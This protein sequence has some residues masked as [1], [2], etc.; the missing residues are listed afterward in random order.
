MIH[1]HI[2]IQNIITGKLPVP[3]EITLPEIAID[4]PVTSTSTSTKL[5]ES[6]I[7]LMECEEIQADNE[8]GS[9]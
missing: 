1:K 9:N 3:V 4:P 6:E 7:T 2:F 5:T 8:L